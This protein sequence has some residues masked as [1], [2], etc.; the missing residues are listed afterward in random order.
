MRFLATVALMALVLGTTTLA[1]TVDLEGVVRAVDGQART[2]TIERKTASGPKTSTVD[3]A[4][5]AG[6]LD[7]IKPGAR[8]TYS[9]D[10]SL[11]VITAITEGAGGISPF[12]T[13]TTWATND[14]GMKIRVIHAQDG[15]F[16]GLLFNDKNL[17]RELHGSFA[18]SKVSWLAKDVVPLRGGP[19]GEDNV[20]VIKRDK[21]GT[22]IDFKYGSNGTF[23]VYLV[24]DSTA[25][26][27]PFVGK[28]RGQDDKIVR[29]I[30]A[31]KTFSEQLPDGSTNAKGNWKPLPDNSGIEVTTDHGFTI[32]MIEI[33]QDHLKRKTQKTD[34]IDPKKWNGAGGILERVK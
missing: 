20:G 22:R 7:G 15:T 1:D 18:G 34:N 19:P 23:A 24:S 28:W 13:G 25:P 9:Y 6:D 16:V 5:S 30:N 33:D 17:L 32:R 2:I 29:Q 10:T 4:V 26:E 11:E 21:T 8:V 12:A 31:D 3:V 14:G 27:S